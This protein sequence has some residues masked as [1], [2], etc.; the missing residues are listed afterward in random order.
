MSTMIFPNLPVKNVEASKAFFKALGYDH[1]PRFSDENAVSIVIS[2]TIVVML[3][4][5]PYFQTFTKKAV[6]DTSTTVEALI[7]LS[8]ESRQQVD[9]LVDAALAA[10]GTAA[11]EAKDMGF[12]YGRD[13]FDLDGHHWEI[14]H[15][16]LSAM[17]EG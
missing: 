14:V 11:G 17:P 1:D 7:A 12:M 4:A 13:F 5:E 16:D 8:V 2:D 10:G 3:L 6:A 9:E 15:M